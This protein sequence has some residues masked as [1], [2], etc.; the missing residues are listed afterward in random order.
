MKKHLIIFGKL[1]LLIKGGYT[2]IKV[3]HT[4]G[5]SEMTKMPEVVMEPPQSATNAQVGNIMPKPQ[6]QTPLSNSLFFVTRVFFFYPIGIGP[7]TL[8]FVQY[9]I[10]L[11]LHT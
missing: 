2:L 11:F 9:I 6:T 8:K 5:Q 7:Y 1:K 4:K 3:I 10:N